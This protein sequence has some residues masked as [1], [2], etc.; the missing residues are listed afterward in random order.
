MTDKAFCLALW[1]Q[2]LHTHRK[3]PQLPH[4]GTEP[5]HLFPRRFG[6][7]A[8]QVNI[9]AVIIYGGCWKITDQGLLGV[10]SIRV[11]D[12]YLFLLKYFAF[13]GLSD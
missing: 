7:S 3:F 12:V 8:E 6:S 10:D 4:L 13:H 9:K 2:L 5:V 11:W 1:P